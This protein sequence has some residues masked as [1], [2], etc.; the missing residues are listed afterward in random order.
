MTVHLRVVTVT[1]TVP[2]LGQS[3][4]RAILMVNMKV[5]VSEAQP[6]SSGRSLGQRLTLNGRFVQARVSFKASKA[7]SWLETQWD[8]SICMVQSSSPD[9]NE[10]R[11]EA[12]MI[13][14]SKP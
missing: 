1:F 8:S 11:Q 6:S 9:E 12:E 3:P 2:K 4:H 14:C 7:E 10:R 13:L 5:L